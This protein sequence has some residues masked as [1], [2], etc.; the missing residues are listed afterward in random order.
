MSHGQL[1]SAVAV[2]DFSLKDGFFELNCCIYPGQQSS[3]FSPFLVPFASFRWRAPSLIKQSIIASAGSQD[4]KGKYHLEAGDG[5]YKLQYMDGSR[6]AHRDA[7]SGDECVGHS[8]HQ[9]SPSRD[10]MHGYLSHTETHHSVP[11]HM[12]RRIHVI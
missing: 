3:S 4:R 6:D 7:D 9:G 1:L 11:C 5:G 2:K 10:L 12:R 8:A